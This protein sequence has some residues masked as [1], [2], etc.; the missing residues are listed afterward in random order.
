MVIEES[1][2]K[3]ANKTLEKLFGNLIHLT[4]TLHT[5]TSRVHTLC[6]CNRTFNTLYDIL[7]N[8]INC[9]KLKNSYL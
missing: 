3:K 7:I 4:N 5:K 6:K 2:K 8:K 1:E 9:S